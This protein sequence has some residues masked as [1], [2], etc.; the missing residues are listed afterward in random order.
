[1]LWLQAIDVILGGLVGLA[2]SIAYGTNQ[3]VIR[4]IRSIECCP[5]EE[6]TNTSETLHRTIELTQN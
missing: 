2:N 4:K 6:N 3:A 5:R 1:M